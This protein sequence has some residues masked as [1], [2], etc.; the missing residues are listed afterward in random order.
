MGSK[1]FTPENIAEATKWSL[2]H[3]KEFVVVYVADNIHAIN[4][5]VRNKISPI[6][7]LRIAKAK[8]EAI[9]EE[10]KAHI[11]NTFETKDLNKIHFA[12]WD[13]LLTE[14]YKQKLAY[15]YD[16]YEKNLE[17]KAHIHSLVADY[18]SGEQ[19]E[20]TDTEIHKLGTYIVEELPELLCRLPIDGLL[21][22]AYVYPFDGE[23]VKFAESL[24]KGE[25][26]PEIKRDIL[27]GEPRLFGELR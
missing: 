14:A 10:A 20:F 17:F 9:L 4:L 6:R 23:V 15:L 3:T 24:Q 8:G 22:E 12:K 16:L 7:A 27:D 19:K 1:W 13:D 5:E 26:F 2:E 18:V 25:I 11:E 21:Y